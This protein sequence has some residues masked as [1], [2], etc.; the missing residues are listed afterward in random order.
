MKRIGV[1][2]IVLFLASCSSTKTISSTSNEVKSVS[3]KTRDG[4]SFKKAIIA[5]SIASEYQYIREV[6][7][8]CRFLEQALVFN[9]KK[10]YDILKFKNSNGEEVS[11]YFDISSFY[12]KGW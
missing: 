1:I 10:P 5:K 2:L 3:E 11:Y 12:G 6:C 4:S 8:E 7:P 9:K